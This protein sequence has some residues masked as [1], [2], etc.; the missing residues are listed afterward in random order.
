MNR[1]K[2]SYTSCT[3]NIHFHLKLQAIYAMRSTRATSAI[4][5]LNTRS[6]GHRYTMALTGRG[7]FTLH[8]QCEDGLTQLGNPLALDDF[9]AFVDSLGPQK[10]R[11]ITKNDALFAKQLVRNSKI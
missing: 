10:L 3:P 6:E 11:R 4:N 1:R 5:R 7:L 8:E 2:V 9:V